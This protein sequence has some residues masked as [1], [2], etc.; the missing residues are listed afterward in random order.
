MTPGVHKVDI[1]KFHD[2]SSSDEK[3]TLISLKAPNK[4]L[5]TFTCEAYFGLKTS[6]TSGLVR[7]YLTCLI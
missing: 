3:K 4:Y 6:V 1:A 5:D 2:T 7:P